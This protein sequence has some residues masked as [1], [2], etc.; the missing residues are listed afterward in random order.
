MLEYGL[1]QD[2]ENEESESEGAKTPTRF[3]LGPQERTSNSG[4]K[5]TR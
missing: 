1:D 4:S 5:Q 3:T 2:L